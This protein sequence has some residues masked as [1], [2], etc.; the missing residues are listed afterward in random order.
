M[1]IYA[2]T[3]QGA[4]GPTSNSRTTATVKMGTTIP[5]YEVVADLWGL[6]SFEEA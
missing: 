6:E 2:S 1:N 3:V 5:K 4:G